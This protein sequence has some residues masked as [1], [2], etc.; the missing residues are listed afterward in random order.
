M[1]GFAWVSHR[2]EY[3]LDITVNNSNTLSTASQ[4]LLDQLSGPI[5]ITA[6]IQ[7]G[8]PLRKQISQLVERYLQHKADLSL[9]F[10]DPA[11]DP[12]RIR[13][14]NIGKEGAVVVDYQ[15]RTEKITFLS[16]LSLSNALL[17]LA[18]SQD[19][20]ISFLTGHG[21]RDA[22][23]A[24]NFD[25]GEFSTHLQQHQQNAQPLDL[26]NLSEI[27]NNSALLV[28]ANPR[29]KLLDGELKIL[30]Q[31]LD[32][33]GNLL[34]LV[35]PDQDTL[36][37]LL[38]KLG[39]SRLP[40]VLID[41]EVKLY[42][43]DHPDFIV[44]NSYPTPHSITRNLETMSLFPETAALQIIPEN[45]FQSVSFL[46]SSA[47]AWNETEPRQSPLSINKTTEKVG[48]LSFGLALTRQQTGKQ[49]RIVVIGDGDFLS[50]S[51]LGNV[52]NLDLGLRI[53]KWLVQDDNYLEIPAR[54]TPDNSLKL[55]P[56]VLGSMGL[57]FLVVVPLSLLGSGFWI[58]RQRRRR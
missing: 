31:Y 19:H 14:L 36:D 17:Q 1:I 50:N 15:G 48:P 25:L 45:T 34:L 38:S 41:P 46:T 57:G 10:V 6:Y 18:Y 2:Y 30:E 7:K 37:P 47:K 3:T 49:Q 40:G 9:N 26:T 43:I 4:K 21:E 5:K 56:I 51:Y 55:A 39:I 53:I 13:E 24:A 58:W 11:S 33:G 12:A 22:L 35:E 8:L 27:P 42:G 23:G 54:I 20:W 52:G 16:E 44:I 28:I 32:Q 29:V